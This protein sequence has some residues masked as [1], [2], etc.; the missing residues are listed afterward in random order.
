MSPGSAYGGRARPAGILRYDACVSRTSKIETV[1]A[2]VA[3]KGNPGPYGDPT[4]FVRRSGLR[5]GSPRRSAPAAPA[6]GRAGRRLFRHQAAERRR[7]L[8][9]LDADCER[10]D[11]GVSTTSGDDPAA[12]IAKGCEA[13]FKL[14]VYRPVERIRDRR[15]PVVDEERGVVVATAFLDNPRPR[16][17]LSIRPMVRAT[18]FS[19]NIRTAAR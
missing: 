3:R 15:Y 18:R 8:T 9:E 19:S 7:S 5:S 4:K 1:R 6:H 14:G 2:F 10:I 12:K 11:N 13:Q 17:E 16:R